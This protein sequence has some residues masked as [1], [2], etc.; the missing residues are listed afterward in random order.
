MT[1]F[2][3]NVF[4]LYY[5]GLPIFCAVN[6]EDLRR[7]IRTLWFLRS[8]PDKKL[9]RSVGPFNLWRNY[10]FRSRVHVFRHWRRC[11]AYHKYLHFLWFIV[12]FKSFILCAV[13]Q[14]SLEDAA[15]RHNTFGSTIFSKTELNV[16]HFYTNPNFY[17]LFGR[18]SP[19]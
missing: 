16:T 14:Y 18:I 2:V 4:C 1:Y 17:W 7:F 8:K 3:G 19:S 6:I 5:F 11:H 13:L 9:P 15:V 12:S 10:F